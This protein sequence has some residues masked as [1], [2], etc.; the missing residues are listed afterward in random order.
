[1]LF[2]RLQPV[3]PRKEYLFKIH[4]SNT[5]SLQQNS[6]QKT[7]DGEFVFK[8]VLPKAVVCA[9]RDDA[10]K[11]TYVAGFLSRYLNGPLP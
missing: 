7:Y 2:G 5:G 1:M 8:P 6:R 9:I 4:I 3:G 11:R 10:Y